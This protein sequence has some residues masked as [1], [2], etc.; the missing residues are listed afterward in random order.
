MLKSVIVVA[1]IHEAIHSGA[2]VAD[3]RSHVCDRLLSRPAP[4]LTGFS[5][6][7]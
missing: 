4:V 3:G 5:Y 1:D 6:E 7:S 2:D